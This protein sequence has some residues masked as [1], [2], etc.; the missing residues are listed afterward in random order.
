MEAFSQF[1]RE[2]ENVVE[3]PYMKILYTNPYYQNIQNQKEIKDI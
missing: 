2:E 3:E 1:D